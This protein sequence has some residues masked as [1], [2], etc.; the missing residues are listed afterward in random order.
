[1]GNWRQLVRDVVDE[2][3]GVFIPNDKP[4]AMNTQSPTLSEEKPM[5]LDQQLRLPCRHCGC[6]RES[7][8]GQALGCFGGM[9]T[10][11]SPAL[12]PAPEKGGAA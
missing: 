8:V 2:N 4:T 7:H 1:M 10:C 6:R 3:P 11:W 12:P 5:T 9:G